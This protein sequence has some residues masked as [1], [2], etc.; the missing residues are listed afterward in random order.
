MFQTTN[1]YLLDLED[2]KYRDDRH[3]MGNFE[4]YSGGSYMISF[5]NEMYVN[6]MRFAE[7]GRKT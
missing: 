5:T 6:N 3:V 4:G 2:V 1:Q 7:F